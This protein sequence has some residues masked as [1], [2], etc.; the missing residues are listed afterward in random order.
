MEGRQKLKEATELYL[1]EF[2]LEEKIKK[3]SVINSFQGFWL[4]IHQKI[5]TIKY[6]K[7]SKNH[8]DLFPKNN[9]KAFKRAFQAVL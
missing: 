8:L 3:F 7:I 2:A 5:G 4:N 1:G 6:F 9:K